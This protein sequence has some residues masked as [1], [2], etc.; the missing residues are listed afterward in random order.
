[1]IKYHTGDEEG[2]EKLMAEANSLDPFHS[3][4][5]AIPGGYDP[6]DEISPEHG[7]FFR[8]F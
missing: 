2:G 5:F 6:P 7:Y 8:P 1:M 4:A 3:K